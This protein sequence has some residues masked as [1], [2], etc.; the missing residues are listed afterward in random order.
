MTLRTGHQRP[1][2]SLTARRKSRAFT[3]MELLMAIVAGMLVAMAAFMFSKTSTRFF[4]SEARIAS[5]QMSVIAGFQRLQADI[6]RAGYLASPN[7]VRDKDFGRICAPNYTS[8]PASMKGT[9]GAGLAGIRI[10]PGGSAT[11]VTALP[12]ANYPDTLRL[13]GSFAATDL[14]PINSIEAGANGSTVYFASNNGPMSRHGVVDTTSMQTVFKAGRLLRILDQQ[15]K[16]EYGIISDSAFP[17]AGQPTVYLSMFLP[18]KGDAGSLCGINGLGTGSQASVISQ[19]E[20]GISRMSG[21]NGGNSKIYDKTIYSEAGT[22]LGDNTRTELVRREIAFTGT[23]PALA[24]D[25]N[26]EIVAEYAV[27]LRF[28]L[29]VGGAAGNA[30]L[31]YVTPSTAA[32]GTTTTPAGSYVQGVAASGPESVR[33]VEVRLVVRSREV[34]NM[35]AIDPTVTGGGTTLDGGY[36]FGFQLANNGGVARA[37]TLIANVAL[38]NMRGDAW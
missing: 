16:Q 30:G 21:L 12:D 22:A 11:N 27:D 10:T 5:A 14:F 8:W 2:D 9:D 6:A 7:V 26:A 34:E 31:Q 20:Y 38:Q 25:G 36:I 15:G 4:A 35:T 13:L 3:L 19:V 24:A 23:I 28:G 1:Q 32:I 29:W 33:A 18:L 17:T 37:R